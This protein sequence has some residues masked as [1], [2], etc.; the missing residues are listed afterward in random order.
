MVQRWRRNDA[1][2]SIL[3]LWRVARW[4]CLVTLITAAT[5][6]AFAAK[7]PRRPARVAYAPP[8]HPLLIVSIDGLSW[9]TLRAELSRLP[10]LK[11]L[12][13]RGVS[14]PLRT[15]LPSMT[16]PAHVSMMTGRMPWRHGVV[17]NRWLDR[18]QG[19]IVQAHALPM[20]VAVSGATLWGA[21]AAAGIAS[22][23]ISWPATSNAEVPRWNLPEVP[24]A[25][26]LRA[27]S[28]AGL[29]D[30]LAAAGVDLSGLDAWVRAEGDGLDGF[31]LAAAQTLWRAHQPRLVALHLLAYDAA[32]HRYG[33]ASR[34]ALAALRACDRRI[35]ELLK[36]YGAVAKTLDVLVVSDHGF[37]E[38]HDGLSPSRALARLQLEDDELAALTPVSNGQS[39]WLY[40]APGPVGAR[41][42]KRA[43]R[44]LAR[45]GRVAKVLTHKALRKT[46]LGDASTQPR[47]PDAALLL[48]D[49]VMLH[50]PRQASRERRPGWRGMHGG[51]PLAA[52]MHGVWIGAGPCFRVRMQVRGLRV[53]DVA[54]TAA[55]ALGI[56]MPP[57]A[58]GLPL[59]GR[60]RKDVLR[61]AIAPNASPPVR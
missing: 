13:R 53:V 27:A 6:P 56:Q 10:T 52:A 59:D 33:P 36:T 9:P 45:D 41:A 22:A 19:A 3:G 48:R 57:A 61:C 30:E 39:L 8:P 21:A 40:A 49:Q 1:R 14:G 46:G 15:V 38:V 17:G 34:Q 25:D 60:A 50:E 32:A 12:H 35:A 47:A 28:S 4:L 7:R 31:S 51:S 42:L 29:F 26:G 37:H 44:G 43:M 5:T 18:A 55:A 2:R 16:W 58:D 24:E 23:A 11:A 54:P 20:A